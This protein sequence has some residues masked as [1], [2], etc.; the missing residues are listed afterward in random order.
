MLIT[1]KTFENAA[2]EE[3]VAMEKQMNVAIEQ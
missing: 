3:T 1:Q 2:N